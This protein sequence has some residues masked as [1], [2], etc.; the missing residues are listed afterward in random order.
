MAFNK[1]RRTLGLKLET[2]PYTLESSLTSSDYN[3][4]VDNIEYDPNVQVTA[5]KLARG[6]LSLDQVV[7]GKQ[8]VKVKFRAEIYPWVTAA[9]AWG[10]VLKICGFSES[11]ST[12]NGVTYQVS[13]LATNVPAT[14]EIPEMD[15]GT[16]PSFIVVSIGGL[17]GT[18]SIDLKAGVPAYINFDG[19]GVLRGFTERSYANRVSPS[20]TDAAA[21]PAFLGGVVIYNSKEQILDTFKLTL[22]NKVEL[23]TSPSVAQGFLGAHISGRDPSADIDPDLQPLSVENYWTSFTAAQNA[24]QLT[25]NIGTQILIKAPKAQIVQAMKTGEREGHLTNTVKLR[26]CRNAGDDELK[27]C[28]GT[29]A[30]I[31]AQ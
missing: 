10:K 12:G 18:V 20:I 6:D 26:L 23:Y 25:A 4:R 17:M 3:L 7:I 9:P 22:A 16:S 21:C 27:I 28:T 15:E 31:A 29:A 5:R 11:V 13:S 8:S 30:Y 2:V 24:A 19:D 14:L 1:E